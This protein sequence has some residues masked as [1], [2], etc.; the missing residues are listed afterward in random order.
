MK[1]SLIAAFA[2]TCLVAPASGHTPSTRSLPVRIVV[3]AGDLDLGTARD[4][5]RLDIRIH[6]AAAAACGP[7]STLDLVGR[8]VA[9]RCTAATAA[10]MRPQRDRLVE[11]ARSAQ[12]ARR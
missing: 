9:A 8:N 2:A 12:I 7:V 4:V 1:N 6:R 5:A 10:A 11:Q 3:P